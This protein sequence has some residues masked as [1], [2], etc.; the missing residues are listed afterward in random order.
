MGDVVD[1]SGVFDHPDAAGC[2]LTR[3]GWRAR[4]NHS[5]AAWFSAFAV[6]KLVPR[7]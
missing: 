4:V 7:Q 1:V 3:A 2:T 5:A 6:E